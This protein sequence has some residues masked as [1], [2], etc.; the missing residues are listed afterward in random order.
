V[1]IPSMIL[2]NPFDQ[3]Q[4]IKFIK[5][6]LPDFRTDERKV[7]VAKSGFSSITKLGESDS[8]STSVLI[9]KSNKNLASRITLANNSFKILKTYNIYRAL[10]VYVN[11]DDS[12]WR[13]SLLTTIPTFDS[14]GKVILS[15][16]N[17]RRHSYVLGSDVGIATARRYLANMGPINDFVDLQYR[18][19][20]E[21]VNKDFYKAI[22][23]HFYAL[24][25]EASESVGAGAILKLDKSNSDEDRKNYAVRLLGRIVFLWFLKQK[26]SMSGLQLLPGEFLEI[27]NKKGILQNHL[28]PLFFE[29][30]NKEIKNRHEKFTDG[31][32]KFIPYLNGGLFHPSEGTSGDHY[33]LDT[34]KSSVEISDLW[35]HDLFE[36]LNTFNFT[37]DEN[38]EN[39]VDLSIDPEML[40]RI[41]ENL[42]AEINPE[43]G[44][45]ARKSTGSYYTPRSIVNLMVDK[46]LISYFNKAT[47]I[48]LVKLRALISTDRQDDL[49][50]PL[51]EEDKSKVVRAVK[52]LTILDPAC[53]S[54]AFPMGILQK[55]LWVLN[56][57]DPS[58]EEYL[59]SADYVGTE[60]WLSES[61]TDYLRKQKIIRDTIFGVD[62]QSI[63][64]EIAKLRCFLTLIVDQE[65]DDAAPNRGVVPLPNLDFKFVCA[66]SLIPRMKDTQLAFGDDPLLG[67]K[68]HS[69]R[70]RFFNTSNE[71]KKNR[72]KSEYEKLITDDLKLFQE[73]QWSLQL[74][75]FR[76]FTNN[77]RAT[78][79]DPATMFGFQFFDI[80]IGNPPY[81]S[82]LAAKKILPAELRDQYKFIYKSASG[83]Y[84]M[85]L[86]FLELGLNL[87]S[88][89]GNL[90]LITPTKFLSAKYGEAFR[91]IA[92]Q[93]LSEIADF[94]NARI[95]DSAGVSTFVSFYSKSLSAKELDVTCNVYSND[96]EKPELAKTFPRS[97]LVEFPEQ[98]WGHLKWGSYELIAKI[99]AESVS[100]EKLFEVVASST[101]AEADDWAKLISVTKT[102]TSYKMIN[103]GTIRKF[104][105]LWGK[106]PY[107]NKKTRILTPYLETKSIGERRV[108]MFSSPK[109]IIAKLSKHLRASLDL[110]GDYASS[111]SVFIIDSNSPYSL[112]VLA[113]IMNSTV[114]DYVYRTTFSGLNLL[115]SFQFQ[116]PQIRILPIPN[117]VPRE[118]S[119]QIETKVAEIRSTDPETDLIKSLM[120]QLDQLVYQAYHLS[121]VDIET[122]ETVIHN[123]S[124]LEISPEFVLDSDLI[125]S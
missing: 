50:F 107:S 114:M 21:T 67:D 34:Q 124:D 74:K 100:T 2:S 10:I 55:L 57:V 113:A 4:F 83:A 108:R 58:G 8:L 41:F 96:Y 110:H 66:D 125:D 48:D 102:K 116:A 89:N 25:G 46:S 53:G 104:E 49:E 117:H 6:F 52:K 5:D 42:L 44:K 99:Y 87:L 38:L 93:S 112:T 7:E 13:L 37:I 43:T 16:S 19:S 71:D 29:I 103:T 123:L 9:V 23:T 15:Y 14:T 59:E 62:I 26:R 90:V 120:T 81:I 118:L 22:S 121:A 97:S 101:A 30:L 36:T 91:G 79:F 72:L 84:D 33:N 95:F 1:T 28:Q 35:F 105:C 77:A 80:V 3:N 47:K 85:Y 92:H 68:L 119:K 86:L 20:V 17:P 39:D 12:I 88:E 122:I 82:A 51:S 111:N 40:G 64:V 60:N 11:D 56:Q 24:V 54:G 61:R 75:S 109:L 31:N 45:I 18:F 115:G 76:P 70:K 69:L 98:T 65:I 27:E 94:D 78:F 73:S 63:A 106:S 32:L